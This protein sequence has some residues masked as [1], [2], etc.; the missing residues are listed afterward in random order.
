VKENPNGKYIPAAEMTQIM[1]EDEDAEVMRGTPFYSFDTLEALTRASSLQEAVSITARVRAATA[2]IWQHAYGTRQE[3]ASM[4]T[5]LSNGVTG[6]ANQG[7]DYTDSRTPGR[8]RRVPAGQEM[9][10]PPDGTGMADFMQVANGDLKMASSAAAAP[11][12][13]TGADDGASYATASESGTPFVRNGES[14]QE[15]YK[16]QFKKCIWRA[17]RWARRCGRIPSESLYVVE[18][19]IEAPTI[20][21]ND[22]ASV[23]QQ[24]NIYL[25]SKVISPQTV[26]MKL[27]LDTN[28]EI[29][30]WK[31]WG[32]AGLD[33]NA[34]P[35][36]P[37]GGGMPGEV[38][39]NDPNAQP[40]AVPGQEMQ[41][42]DPNA[43]PPEAGQPGVEQQPP[44]AEGE[45]EQPQEEQPQDLGPMDERLD[46][47]ADI[48]GGA[49]G[50][51]ALSMLDQQKI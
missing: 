9:K 30:N 13:M 36:T 43:Q 5:G 51:K 21:K 18:L 2:E 37:P 47:M 44:Q 19:Q 20:H 25:Q 45:E 48:I 14:E 4:P 32:E 6:S 1:A 3:I 49:Y 7:Y 23:A 42:G 38:D 24:M 40:G 31:E 33:P 41:P 17:L 28:Q 22:E 50:S 12:Y 34:P 27:G 11:P 10:Q 15:H 16:G 8:T 26:Q 29:I 46:A 39:P 35:G